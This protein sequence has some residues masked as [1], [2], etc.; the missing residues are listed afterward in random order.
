MIVIDKLFVNKDGKVVSVSVYDR[1][2]NYSDILWNRPCSTLSTLVMSGRVENARHIRGVIEFSRGIPTEAYCS[3]CS[4]LK[5]LMDNYNNFYT[6]TFEDIQDVLY[7]VKN[8]IDSFP[9]YF[10]KMYDRYWV[11][12]DKK[13]MTYNIA[14]ACM[15][16]RAFAYSV[17]HGT[18]LLIDYVY[19]SG[20]ISTINI[21]KEAEVA[22]KEFY[23][24]KHFYN[25]YRQEQLL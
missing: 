4:K 10:M 6:V 22:I 23:E 7:E 19:K 11:S 1:N 12:N 2:T 3:K 21:S 20:N 9:F 13:V 24:N 17:N 15:R 18:R 14:G 16:D 5:Y 25:P 8:N